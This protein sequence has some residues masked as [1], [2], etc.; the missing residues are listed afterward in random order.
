ML[1]LFICDYDVAHL[2]NCDSKENAITTIK[3]MDQNVMFWSKIIT[4]LHSFRHML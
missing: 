2:H 1:A 4:R 3:K